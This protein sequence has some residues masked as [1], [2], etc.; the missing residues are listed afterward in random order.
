MTIVQ[1][2]PICGNS[3]FQSTLTCKDHSTSHETFEL[4]SCSFC[5]FVFTSPRPDEN[6]IHKY[7][8][9]DDYISHTNKANSLIN[10][11]YLTARSR[12]LQWKI[13]LLQKYS[14]SKT[15]K[16]LDYGCGTGE[17]LHTCK[18]KNWNIAG[19]EPSASAREQASKKNHVKI[20]SSIPELI[21]NEFDIITLWHVLEHVPNLTEVL[22]LLKSKLKPTGILIIAVPNHKSWDAK[23]YKSYWAGYDVPRHLWHFS[24]KNIEQ[25]SKNN[26]L[27]IVASIP[28]IL[29]S[30][31]ISLL[32]EKYK[33]QNRT[34]PIGLIK[35]FFNGLISNIK[36]KKTTEYSSLIYIVSK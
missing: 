10:R 31:Y 18:K 14:D 23:H 20:A 12:T 19:I 16:L 8:A 27:K 1:T 36:A 25:L 11:L 30:F 15:I 17:F 21:D 34:T 32:S 2:C 24:Q 26:G 4:Q 7:Y 28:M 29:D 9:S 35:A 6:I 13:K 33:S 3:S 5:N 22:Q